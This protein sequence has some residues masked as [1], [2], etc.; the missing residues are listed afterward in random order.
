MTKL[1]VNGA[2]LKCSFGTTPSSLVVIPKGTPTIIE[3]QPVATIM[4]H[5][6][7]ANIPPF[8]MCKSLINPQVAAANPAALANPALVAAATAASAAANSV[9]AAVANPT[10]YETAVKV[11]YVAASVASSGVSTPMPCI[12]TIPAPWVPGTLDFLIDNIPALNEQC[13]C[14]CAWGGVIEITE[15]EQSTV[16]AAQG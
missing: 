11:A 16:S 5:A 15:P 1:V 9:V 6:P 7:I 13:V 2:R 12:S 3:G 4:D 14:L 10:T 8:G